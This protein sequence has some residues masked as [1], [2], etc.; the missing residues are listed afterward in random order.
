MERKPRE[1]P[2]G[3]PE[4]LEPPI[5][6]ADKWPHHGGPLSAS[7][8]HALT[9]PLQRDSEAVTDDPRG[10]VGLYEALPTLFAVAGLVAIAV[11]SLLV[12]ADE[13]IAIGAAGAIGGMIGGQALARRQ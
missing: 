10:S 3:Q 8:D 2:K 7:K 9:P 12:G 13:S 11:V 5:R 6:D 4:N 1:G